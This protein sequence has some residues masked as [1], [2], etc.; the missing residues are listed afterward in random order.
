MK[1]QKR[2]FTSMAAIIGL[3]VVMGITAHA[4]SLD[5]IEESI[6]EVQSEVDA[7]ESQRYSTQMERNTFAAELDTIIDEMITTSEELAL[8]EDAVAEA[9]ME[10]AMAR[11]DE[12]DQLRSMKKRIRF[13]Y[14]SGGLQIMETLLSSQSM[15]EFLN[16]AEYISQLASHDREML[17][18]FEETVEAV[19]TKEAAL[20]EDVAV[21]SDLRNQLIEKQ[22]QVEVMLAQ[23]D[24]DLANFDGLIGARRAD[25]DYLYAK[26]EQERQ[27]IAEAAAAEAAAAELERQRQE[28][29]EREAANNQPG[30]ANGNGNGNGT[31]DSGSAPPPPPP[32][33]PVPGGGQLAH[34]LPGWPITSGFG[35]RDF[36]NRHHNGIDI[37][38]PEGTPFFAAE[39][40]TVITSGFSSSAGNWIV[41]NHGNGMTTVYMHNS[42]NQVSVGQQVSRGQQI[43]LVG[44]TGNSFGAHLHFEVRINGVPHNPLNFL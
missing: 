23:A 41:L 40:G 33:D 34:P 13:M 15:G 11:A 29:A 20:R 28:E 25:L 3:C 35:W 38:A 42:L 31:T 8:K 43:G 9:E 7:L 32:A 10:L 14:E 4:G 12:D 44:N 1:K 21:L 22:E 2:G 26:A 37:G 36:D 24:S 39:S 30:N 17:I 27:R 18:V 19:A 5:S 6:E 16:A